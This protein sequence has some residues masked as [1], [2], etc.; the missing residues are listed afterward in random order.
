MSLTA[1]NGHVVKVHYTGKLTDGKVF[2]SSEGRDP[3]EFTLG[4]QQMIVGFEEGILGMAV[5][6]E[7]VLEIPHSKGY[8]EVRQDLIAE[9]SKEQLPKDMEVNVGGKI[10]VT[11]A[12]GQQIPA[13]IVEVKDESII[14]DANHELAGKDLVFEVKLV[15]IQ[16]PDES[17]K[18]PLL[19]D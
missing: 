15:D 3:L 11:V 5:G 10:G 6:E 8:G 18:S 7:K 17:S 16:T 19:F 2:D 14:I 4:K 9:F 12:N 1:Q 13:V